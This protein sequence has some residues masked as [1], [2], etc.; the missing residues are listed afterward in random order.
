MHVHIL[1]IESMKPIKKNVG[2]LGGGD[3]LPAPLNWRHWT[4]TDKITNKNENEIENQ[5]ENEDKD[6]D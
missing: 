1:N 6:T 5:N 3:G 4:R 2:N